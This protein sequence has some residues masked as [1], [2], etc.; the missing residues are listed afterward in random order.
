M[1]CRR[2]IDSLLKE[3]CSIIDV[4][5]KGVRYIYMQNYGPLALSILFTTYLVVY[6]RI[7]ELVY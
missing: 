6:S 7:N 3:R 5:N 1:P 4:S 2:M